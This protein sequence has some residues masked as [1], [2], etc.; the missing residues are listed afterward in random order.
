MDTYTPDFY[1]RLH[2]IGLWVHALEIFDDILE[3]PPSYRPLDFSEH[4]PIKKAL[5]FLE[6]LPTVALKDLGDDTE[7]VVC[8]EKFGNKTADKGEVERPVRLP[9]SHVVGSFC[10]ESWVSPRKETRNTCPVC[11]HQLFAMPPVP[12]QTVHW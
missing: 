9:C 3:Q 12:E 6:T 7:C 8:M 4:P 5:N 10:I 1:M 11:R 2:L